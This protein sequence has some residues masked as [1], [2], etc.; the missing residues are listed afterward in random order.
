[1][2]NTLNNLFFRFG[3]AIPW[4]MY[5]FHRDK[6]RFALKT[7]AGGVQGRFRELTESPESDADALV[8][9]CDDGAERS[10]S[11]DGD[12]DDADNVVV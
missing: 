8:E 7:R 5:R 10:E 12:G 2:S 3:F 6:E 11:V 1:M 9:D 4:F